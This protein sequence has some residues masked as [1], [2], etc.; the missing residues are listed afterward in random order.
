MKLARLAVACAAAVILA[1]CNDSSLPPGGTYAP[2][3]GVVL[4]AATNQPLSG[5]TVTVDTVLT[6]KTDAQ[7]KFTFAQVPVGEADV[8]VQADGYKDASEPTRIDPSK[9]NALTITLAHPTPAAPAS[10]RSRAA[11]SRGR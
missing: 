2:L 5:A 3:S 11:R 8:L 9:P 4:D 1:A 10:Y 7:G 6:T